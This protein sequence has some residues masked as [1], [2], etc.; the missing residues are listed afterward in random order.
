MQSTENSVSDNAET[1]DVSE[2]QW[3][4]ILSA[5]LRWF[6]LHGIYF[7]TKFIIYCFYQWKAWVPVADS[8]SIPAGKAG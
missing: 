7:Q 3:E 2:N 4:V 6:S 1:K 5:W 8:S